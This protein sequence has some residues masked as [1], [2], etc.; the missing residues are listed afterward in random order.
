ME[1]E[2]SAFLASL[3]S[4]PAYSESTR[5]AYASD[6]RVFLGYLQRTLHR[7]PDLGDL[8]PQ[9][10]IEFLNAESEA[11]RRQ[12]TLIRR[13]ATLRRFILYLRQNGKING[14]AFDLNAE[15]FVQIILAG[16]SA[17]VPQY[18]DRDQV[19]RL[20]ALIETSPRPRARRDQAI[21][22]LLL[23]TGLSV[24]VL[25][26]LNLTDI[27]LQTRSLQLTTEN[28]Q[29]AWMPLG[30]ATELLERY[31]R[32]GRPELNAPPDE[33]ALFVS[34]M[35]ERMSRQGIWQIFRHWGQM[36]D[37]AIQLSPRLIR[38]TAVLR[39]MKNRRPANE[40]QILLGH[41][42]PLSTQALLRRLSAAY[43]DIDQ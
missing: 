24:T 39:M 9:R 11:G 30:N 20:W 35:G 40:I 25:V 19:N 8:T 15:D 28:G 43:G 12:N 33:T 23:E 37:P 31:L 18:L 10:V 27:D 22:M 4:Q 41:S 36:V 42:N 6:L 2:V 3:T 7:T 26:A 1:A 32:Q 16:S 17:E 21:L 38:H 14:N 5:L 13:R 34:Q 29:K